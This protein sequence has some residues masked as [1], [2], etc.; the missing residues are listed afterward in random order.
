MAQ[1][2]D[3][4]RER[5]WRFLL[6]L[7][8]FCLLQPKEEHKNIAS[9]FIVTMLS[10]SSLA[11]GTRVECVSSLRCPN[12]LLS[13]PSYRIST[14]TSNKSCSRTSSTSSTRRSQRLRAVELGGATSAAVS[15]LATTTAPPPVDVSWQ[16]VVGSFGR[17][18][19]SPLI[20]GLYFIYLFT[21]LV[22]SLLIEFFCL[23]YI[24]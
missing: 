20:I 13:S 11:A 17:I 21:N 16:I 7:L 12:L 14:V 6:L 22:V 23:F 2:S 9:L 4:E 5:W 10:L 3:R 18:A 24:Q 1:T 19:V 15:D 8:L